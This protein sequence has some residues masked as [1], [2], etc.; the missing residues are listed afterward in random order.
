MMRY[1]TSIWLT[2]ENSGSN[3]CRY[4]SLTFNSE[5]GYTLKR[6]RTKLIDNEKWFEKYRTLAYISYVASMI[7][8]ILRNFVVI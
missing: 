8:I 5:T 4:S 6:K 1:Q 7:K 3:F 2:L